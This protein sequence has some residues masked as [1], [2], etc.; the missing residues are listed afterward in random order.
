M[1]GL[2]YPQ[3]SNFNQTSQYGLL[4]S[5]VAWAR[6]LL[7]EIMNGNGQTEYEHTNGPVWWGN[8]DDRDIYLSITDCSGFINALLK[9][10]YGIPNL[11][12]EEWFGVKRPYASTYYKIINRQNGFTKINNIKDARVGDFI[13]TRFPPGT[14]KGDDTGHIMMINND[15]EHIYSH[16]ENNSGYNPRNPNNKNSAPANQWRV[17][18]IDQTASPHGKYDTRYIDGEEKITGLG[19]GYIKIYTDPL[20]RIQGYSWSL[21]NKSK[22]IDKSVHPILIGRLDI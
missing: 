11:E 7:K 21:S 6:L 9:K 5:Q 22:Y 12:F 1:D 16:L 10:S 19:S 13:V 2:S 17:N 4:P 20:G 18:I 3:N 14:S 15:P 8:H